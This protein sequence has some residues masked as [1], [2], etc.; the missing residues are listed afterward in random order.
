[1]PHTRS[2]PFGIIGA[3]LKSTPES[4]PSV[5]L[6][7]KQHAQCPKITRCVLLLQKQHAQY[8]I[9]TMPQK[10]AQRALTPEARAASCSFG[11]GYILLKLRDPY[12]VSFSLSLSLSPSLPPS[13]SLCRSFL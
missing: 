12:C 7:Q 9:K 1:M 3:P 6:L 8:D 11:V 13:L 2:S 10:R 5:L 4:T